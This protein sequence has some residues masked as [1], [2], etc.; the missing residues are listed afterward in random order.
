M[1][2]M[3]ALLIFHLRVRCTTH[4]YRGSGQTM[5]SMIAALA[6]LMSFVHGKLIEYVGLSVDECPKA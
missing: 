1:K 3:V 5:A 2:E 4:I 6:K